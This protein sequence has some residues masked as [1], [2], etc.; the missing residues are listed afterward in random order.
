[1]RHRLLRD[2]RRHSG[3]KDRDI[4]RREG[5]DV[6]VDFVGSDATLQTGAAAARMMGDLTLVGL[7]GGG[8]ALLLKFVSPPTRWLP[9][10]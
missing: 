10:Q 9:C 3:G 1:M 6:V 4:T 2:G 7:T 8:L 5:A